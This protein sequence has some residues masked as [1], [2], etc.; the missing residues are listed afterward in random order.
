M[1]NIEKAKALINTFVTGDTEM[2]KSLLKEG[3]IQHNLAYGTGAEAFCGSVSYLGSAPIKTTVNTIRAFEDGDKV[4]LHTIY[5]FAGAGEQVAFDVF[6]FE[7]GLIA[8]HWDNLASFNTCKSKWTY[9][10]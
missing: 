1:N 6:R 9:T 10:S 2:A 4:I 3:Y 7:D 8:E 5:N